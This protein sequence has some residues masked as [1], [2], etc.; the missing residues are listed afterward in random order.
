MNDDNKK[1]LEGLPKIGLLLKDIR[2]QVLIRQYTKKRVVEELRKYMKVVRNSI[3]QQDHPAAPAYD[4]I[5]DTFV[6]K[7]ET[8]LPQNLRKAINGTGIVIHEGLGRAPLADTALEACREAARHYCTLEV[9][10]ETG[11]P[12]DRLVHVQDLLKRLT[13]AEAVLVVNN[14][15][16]ALLLI[17]NTMA[18]GKDVFIAREELVETA[19]GFRILDVI[20]TSGARAV[21]VGA[22]NKCSVEDFRHALKPDSG[23]ILRV[24][25]SNY[26]I[27]GATERISLPELMIL[28]HE[29]RVPV[30]CD[31]GSGALVNLSRWGLA[32]EPTVQEVLDNGVDV[33]CFSG[34]ELLGGS[35]CG[36]ILGDKEIIDR[37]KQN[38][39][40]RALRC[41]KTTLTLLEAT[42]RLFQDEPSLLES[43]P[44]MRILTESPDQIK[45]RC[46][47]LKRRLKDIIGDRGYLK[48]QEERSRVGTDTLATETLPSWALAVHIVGLSPK[49]L[50]TWLRSCNPPIFG[51]M[52]E[53]KYLLDCRTILRDEFD[54]VVKAF[55]QI[56]DRRPGEIT[57]DTQETEEVVNDLIREIQS[58]DHPIGKNHA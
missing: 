40:Y 17:L 41:G 1:V 45:R 38:H 52:D 57:P 30:L 5:V 13:G 34:D 25:H 6:E 33:V 20:K 22:T 9:S 39:L 50:D 48:I 31:L 11:M 56:L 8:L 29:S 51:H 21:E 58:N 18:G 2:I 28:A 46:H 16:A 37:L 54:D 3:L 44:V 23:V 49:E 35:Q 36:I 14:N 10:R 4:D 27:S 19:S 55:S 26:Q 43:H 24:H 47:S 15:A 53:H 12:A 7:A 42:L 32:H